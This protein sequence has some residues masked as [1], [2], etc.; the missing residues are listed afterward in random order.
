MSK[1]P[2]PIDSLLPEIVDLV[3]HNPVTLLKAEPGAGKTTRV[4]AALL[5]AGLGDVYVLEPR[6]LATRMAARRVAEEFGE[7]VGRTVGYQVRF[8]EVSSPQTKLWYLTEGV[9]TRK[10]LSDNGLRNAK[11]VVLDEFHERHVETDLALALL[12]KRQTSRGDLRLLI[13]SATLASDE[14][15]SKLGG[16]PMITAPGRVFPV[17]VRYT[18]PSAAPLEVEVAAAVSKVLAETRQHILV[19]L[20]GAAEIRKA[21]T[22]CEPAARQHGAKLLPLHGDL[23]PAEQDEAVARSAQ[24]KIICSTNVAESSVTI[25]GVEAVVDSGLARVMTHSPWSGISRLQVERISKSSAIQRAGR[26]GRTGPGIAIRLYSESDFVRRPDQTA[27]EITRAD[28]SQLLLQLSASGLRWEDLTWLDMPKPEMLEH[29]RALLMQLGAWDSTGTVSST[30]KLMAKLPVHPRLGR[31]V[32]AAAELGAAEQACEVA[33]W[34]S[35][36]RIR[37][38]DYARKRY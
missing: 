3:A 11:V 23:S 5:A 21:I 6:R 2:L 27:P 38:D 14:L 34:L 18:P 28:L 19:F 17:S 1:T 22:A 31:F 20:P 16:V 4:P 15:V 9:L 30:G 8:E 35:E 36:G 25:D 12:R 37:L 32:L 24:R 26:A 29:S 13:M 33:A 7:P 10:L